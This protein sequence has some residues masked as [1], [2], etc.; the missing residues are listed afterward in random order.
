MRYRKKFISVAA[1]YVR[2]ESD[3]EDIVAEAFTKFWDNRETIELSGTPEAYILSMVKNK[4]LD[5]LRSAA[6]RERIEQHIQNEKLRAVQVEI[7]ILASDDNNWMFEPE[8]RKSFHGF[9]NEL[10]ELRREI[11][12]AVKFDGLTY[13]E[14]ALRLGV[15]P[16]KVKKEISA[17]LNSLRAAVKDWL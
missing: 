10:P 4:C 15:S 12:S 3:A 9:L 6:T 17:V 5:Y 14:A 11:F 8:V 13:N 2:N 1:S 7:D 16:R